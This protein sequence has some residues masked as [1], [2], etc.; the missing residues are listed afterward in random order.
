MP[1]QP[2]VNNNIPILGLY[3]NHRER[4]V[5]SRTHPIIPAKILQRRTSG[6]RR[7]TD[8]IELAP[9]GFY[10]FCRIQCPSNTSFVRATNSILISLSSVTL[11]H[12][13][14]HHRP[15]FVTLSQSCFPSLC[16]CS[17]QEVTPQWIRF[18]TKI[19]HKTTQVA[20]LGNSKVQ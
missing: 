16:P 12:P 2:P 9:T 13:R 11:F 14:S 15:I 7:I 20:S 1:N 19:S 3:I 5:S 18:L 17:Q 4:K 6:I 10:I 8:S